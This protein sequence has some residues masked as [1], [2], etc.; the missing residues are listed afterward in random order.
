MENNTGR[1]NTGNTVEDVCEDV[2]QIDTNNQVEN[3]TGAKHAMVLGRWLSDIRV[4]DVFISATTLQQPLLVATH[5]GPPLVFY[6]FM[7]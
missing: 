6:Q 4:E 7:V 5:A 1:D 3:Q 2:D